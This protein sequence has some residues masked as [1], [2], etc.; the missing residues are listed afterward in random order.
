MLELVVV[1]EYAGGIGE[2]LAAIAAAI[3]EIEI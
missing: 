2:R 3:I 1:D